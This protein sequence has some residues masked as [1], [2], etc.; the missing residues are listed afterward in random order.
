MAAKRDYYDILGVTRSASA[1]ELKKAY[2][3]LAIQFH[4]DKNPDN[5]EAEEKFKEAAEAYEVLT[6]AKKRQMYDQFGHAG[7]IGAGGASGFEGFG[8]GGSGSINDIF[9]DIFGD[10]FGGAAG[11]RRGGGGRRRSAA[12][13]GA[14]LKTS[15]DITFEE[16]AFGAEKIITIPRAAVCETCEGSG[17]RK[18]S[19]ADACG[20]CG[21][22]G[23]VMYQQG[24]FS[25]SRTCSQCN[26]SGEVIKDPCGDCSGAGTVKRRTQLAVNIPAG[27]DSGQRLKLRGEGEAGARGGPSGDLYVI[28]NV[29]EHDFFQRDEYDIVCEV[30]ITFTQAALGAEIEVPT[31]KG[32][33]EM[34][35][36]AGTQAGKI[37]RL[38]GKGLPR[39]G[40]YGT[41]DQLVRVSV[42]IPSRLNSEQKDLLRK[43]EA[44]SDS[45][46]HPSHHTFF[47]KMKGLLG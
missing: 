41:G 46:T 31:L 13:P 36:P 38:K 34:K 19:K 42:E 23:E 15:V 43:F 20:Q 32:K 10:F 26:G 35:I 7:V 2:R 22:R 33:V 9:E 40:A 37:F 8:A 5:K 45:S 47:E 39:L 11:G 30:P 24:F 44:A 14:D 6:D 28:I 16:A 21:G 1:D 18:G 29:L 4:P 12:Q 27:V 25:I 3:K 17:A